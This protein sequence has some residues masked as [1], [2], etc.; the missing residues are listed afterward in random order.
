MVDDKSKQE[1]SKRLRYFAHMR[2]GSMK[3]LAANLGVTSSTLSQY[4]TGKSIPGNTMQARLRDIGCD[5]EWLMT[6]E[7][8]AVQSDEVSFSQ[9]FKK[10][11]KEFSTLMREYN[12]F[13]RR[14]Q[15]VESL[16]FTLTEEYKLPFTD[17]EEQERRV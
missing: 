17:R 7:A 9:E 13:N 8:S 11:R 3:E 5:I 2:F 14:L 4:T 16:L 10:I 15:R 12:S 6:G 1:I